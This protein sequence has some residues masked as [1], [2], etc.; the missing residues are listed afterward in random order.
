MRWAL[1]LSFAANCLLL[2]VRVG[3][4]LL[5]G[6]LSLIVAT[7]D[8]VLDAVSSGGWCWV[9]GCQVGAGCGVIKR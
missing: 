8:A 1:N 6:S 3:I 2:A 5:A 7:L 4:A 9:L